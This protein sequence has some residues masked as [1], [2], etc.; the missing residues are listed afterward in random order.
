MG[1]RS[2][3]IG[4]SYENPSA[5]LDFVT[6]PVRRKGLIAVLEVG[7]GQNRSVGLLKLCLFV[8]ID[9]GLTVLE[10]EC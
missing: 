4:E 1:R 6:G 8:Q 2:V 9:S 3:G 5:N 7:I 10:E